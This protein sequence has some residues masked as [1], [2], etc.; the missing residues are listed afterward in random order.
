M[1][2]LSQVSP[3]RQFKAFDANFGVKFYN[4]HTLQKIACVLPHKI[5]VRAQL[6]EVGV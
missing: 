3:S 1:V 6:N 4:I 5:V 2:Y